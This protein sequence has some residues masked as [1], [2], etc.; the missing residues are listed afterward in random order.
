MAPGRPRL[1]RVPLPWGPVVA[2]WQDVIPLPPS[3]SAL[4]VLIRFLGL[5]HRR[6][7]CHRTFAFFQLGL[8][9]QVLSLLPHRMKLWGAQGRSRRTDPPPPVFWGIVGCSRRSDLPPPRFLGPTGLFRRFQPSDY[10]STSRRMLRLIRRPAQMD[11]PAA[12]LASP[13]AQTSQILLLSML[14]VPPAA[15]PRRLSV[16]R[17]LRQGE[18]GVTRC[19]Y[20]RGPP[21]VAVVLDLGRREV[22][23]SRWRS[24]AGPRAPAGAQ[25]RLRAVG[26]PVPIVTQTA[27]TAST[28]A[29]PRSTS[30]HQCRTSA[31]AGP[32]RPRPRQFGVDQSTNRCCPWSLWLILL[33]LN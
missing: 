2:F 15:P 20:P 18:P 8:H 21:Q 4:C 30:F 33:G 12:S 28:R 6:T 32:R 19:K 9:A 27:T 3:V 23:D 22:R 31:R 14:P 5:V 11:L 10:T 16:V 26:L 17:V 13:C 29:V 1:S 24:V 25:Q 7:A